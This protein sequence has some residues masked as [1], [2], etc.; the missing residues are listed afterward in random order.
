[1]KQTE[2]PYRFAL[3]KNR[4]SHSG[5]ECF[6]TCPEKW[7]RQYDVKEKQR[8]ALALIKGNI[9]HA[10]LGYAASEQLLHN[11]RPSI[12]ELMRYTASMVEFEVARS[13]SDSGYKLDWDEEGETIHT[14]R[15]Q[16]VRAVEAYEKLI[17]HTLVPVEAEQMF[18]MELPGRDYVISGRMDIFDITGF[19]RDYKTSGK[20]MEE[21]IPVISDQL[22]LYQIHRESKEAKAGELK[23]QIAGLALDAIAITAGGVEVQPLEVPPRTATE[24]QECL[25]NFDA[26]VGAIRSG[27]FP[28]ANNWRVCSWC[29]YLE[30]CK[31]GVYKAAKEI[32]RLKVIADEAAAAKKA[33]EKQEKD[34][35][36]ADAKAAGLGGKGKKKTKITGGNDHG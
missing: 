25:D 29:G 16:A 7:R 33:K 21:I 28:K 20:K 8:P 32:K 24:K 4:I 34:Q 30:D 5:R 27:Y 15:R 3:P 2:A 10:G 36:K 1:M 14:L 17:G 6:V 18:Y 13:E 23:V 9:V 22:T 12:K 31:P 19:L 35:A 11:P 26:T